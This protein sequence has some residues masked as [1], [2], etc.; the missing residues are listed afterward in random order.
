[1]GASNNCLR[2]IMLN[3]NPTKAGYI[4]FLKQCKPRSAGFLEA[5][6]SGSTLFCTQL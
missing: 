3:P 2:G 1:M 5:C 4:L 6:L